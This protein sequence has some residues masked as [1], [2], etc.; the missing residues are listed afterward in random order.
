MWITNDAQAVVLSLL[1][2]DYPMVKLYIMRA[3]GKSFG[4]NIGMQSRR[5]SAGVCRITLIYGKAKSTTP[6]RVMYIA[7]KSTSVTRGV[8]NDN[9]THHRPINKLQ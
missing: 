5:P 2:A 4:A 6:Q 1:R 3:D 7:H 8:S 9:A